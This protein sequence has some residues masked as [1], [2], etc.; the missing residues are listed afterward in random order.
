VSYVTD[1]SHQFY[2]AAKQQSWVN[3]GQGSPIVF[4]KGV[5][6][7]AV[8]TLELKA[9]WME[10]P[11]YS[12]SDPK[13]QQYLLSNAIVV[14]PTNTQCRS[15]VVALV[16]LH[17]IHKTTTQPTWVWATF[18]HVDNVP[19]PS[20]TSNC[21]NFN[22][23]KCQSQTVQVNQ[24][25]CLPNGK[26]AP[27]TVNVVCTANTS[28]P[29]NLGPGCPAPVPIQ[30]TRATGLDSTAQQINAAMWQTIK[31]SYPTS[32]FQYYQLVDV[33]WSTNPTQDP[34]K[35]QKVP[36][37]PAALTSGNPGKVANSVLETYIQ[38]SQ[39][40][41]CHRY[42]NIAPQTPPPAPVWDGDFSFALGTA[43]VAQTQSKAKANTKKK[44]H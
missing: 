29:Y 20:N 8:G 33:L 41:D 3:N 13:W 35:P 32:V 37:N 11:N 24:S 4:T 42:A 12:A 14:G 44:K 27:A 40:T 43:S 28:P 17:I 31:A 10:V 39:C 36:L 30:V 21:C 19:G 18:E 1:S 5:Q 9:A 25:S 15:T 34:V 7:G 6:N 16:G 23:P 22:N 2:N 26:T 38:S